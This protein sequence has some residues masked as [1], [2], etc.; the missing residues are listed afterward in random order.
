MNESI[1]WAH[2]RRVQD[3]V[4][5]PPH[6]LTSNLPAEIT[7]WLYLSDENNARDRSKIRSLGITHVL[8]LNSMPSHLA[9][10]RTNDLEAI[11]I[12][13]KHIGGMDYE[14]YDMI[15]KHWED[16]LSTYMPLGKAEGRY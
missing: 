11:G 8:S 5:N 7:P 10:Y 12:I 2:I 3:L 13:H 14:G 4:D 16:C 6:P 9:E 1:P 15:G